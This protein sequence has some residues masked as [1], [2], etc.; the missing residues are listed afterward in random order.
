MTRPLT[1]TT[2]KLIIPSEWV[3]VLKEIQ[4]NFPGAV[5]AGGALRDLIT[6]TQ[7][8]DVDIFIPIQSVYDLELEAQVIWD[9]FPGQDIKLD[10]F[11]MYG[12]KVEKDQDRDIFAVFKYQRGDTKFDLILCSKNAISI[13]TFDIN[14][15]QI[16]FDGENLRTTKAFTDGIEN[17]QLKIMNV[18]RTDRNKARMGRL[19][20]KYPTYEVVE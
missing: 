5:I 17:K 18:N 19:K 14:I 7:I 4:V 8:K 6:N 11:S 12:G 10:K 3:E 13:Q 1:V 15:C 2:N 16:L 9:T 20:A